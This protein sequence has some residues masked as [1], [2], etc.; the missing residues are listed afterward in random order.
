MFAIA[1]VAIG[2]CVDSPS[3]PP[4]DMSTAAY[5]HLDYLLGVM[6]ANSIKR[7]AI[8]WTQFRDSVIKTA[9]GAQTIAETYPAIRV[10]LGLL[11]DGHSSYIPAS[12]STI[13]VP[14]HTCSTP[15]KTP[16]VLPSNIG[17]VKVGSFN[18]TGTAHWPSPMA[19]RRRFVPLI[20]MTSSAGSWTFAAMV[21]A[22]CGP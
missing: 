8:N 9:T 10:A 14:T 7:R 2:A 11:G 4:A 15:T 17:Y 5:Q 6:Q 3:E 18:Q 16:P 21:V 20:E 22:T 1:A 19:F 12:G 13:F